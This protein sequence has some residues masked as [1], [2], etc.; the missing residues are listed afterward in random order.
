MVK[1]KFDSLICI[2]MLMNDCVIF[3]K[4]I[5]WKKVIFNLNILF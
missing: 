5:W 4:K 3:Y 2:N 1:D